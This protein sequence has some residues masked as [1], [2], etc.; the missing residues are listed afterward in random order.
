M[1]KDK[2]Y[3]V[4]GGEMDESKQMGPIITLIALIIVLMGFLIYCLMGGH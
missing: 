1:N 4:I 2:K 3:Y